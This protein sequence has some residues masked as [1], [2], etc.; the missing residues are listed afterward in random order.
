MS[1]A[2]ALVASRESRGREVGPPNFS[3]NYMEEFYNLRLHIAYMR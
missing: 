1:E 2:I 3:L